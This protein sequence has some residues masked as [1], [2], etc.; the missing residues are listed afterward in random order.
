MPALVV[1]KMMLMMTMMMV[2]MLLL[3]LSDDDDG[4]DDGGANIDDDDLGGTLPSPPTARSARSKRPHQSQEA[5]LHNVLILSM[6]R[7]LFGKPYMCASQQGHG[8][9]GAAVAA[10]ARRAPT[11]GLCSASALP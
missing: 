9:S 4:A 3:L 10:R 8:P 7:L 11:G 6:I 5:E 1:V 2:M